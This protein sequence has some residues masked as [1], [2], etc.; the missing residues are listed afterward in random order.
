[1]AV[2]RATPEQTAAI[3]ARLAEGEAER[4]RLQSEYE[5]TQSALQVESA[6][7]TAA[8]EAKEAAKAAH[9]RARLGTLAPA[10]AAQWDESLLCRDEALR[11]VAAHVLDQIRPAADYP[12]CRDRSCPCGSETV[13]CLPPQVYERLTVLR[14]HLPA[15]ATLTEYER[16]TEHIGDLDE[17]MA[18]DAESTPIYTATLSVADGPMRFTRTV[19][20]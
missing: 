7:R 5:A 17:A 10:L 20:I 2:C 13:E 4:T 3:A 8:Y 11:V 18:D 16:V 6:A 14:A 19:T 1:M 12:I 15:G 9:L